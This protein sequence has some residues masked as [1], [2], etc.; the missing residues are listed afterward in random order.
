[1]RRSSVI[2]VL[3]RNKKKVFKEREL[4]VKV[5]GSL[6]LLEEFL[7][8]ATLEPYVFHSASDCLL[9]LACCW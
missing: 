9:Q 4:V 5:K 8:L 2:Q 6:M 3:G 1:M 7:E